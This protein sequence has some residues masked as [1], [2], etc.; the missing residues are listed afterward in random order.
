MKRTVFAAMV[1]ACCLL[2]IPKNVLADEAVQPVLEE[3]SDGAEP[4]EPIDSNPDEPLPVPGKVTDLAVG[5]HDDGASAKLIWAES[6]CASVYRIYR[7]SESE[8]LVELGFTE[9]TAYVDDEIM[10]DTIY[11]YYVIP[12]SDD[13]VQGEAANVKLVPAPHEVEGVEAE[14][15]SEK[16]VL[17][18]WNASKF[19]QKYFVYR[20]VKGGS[21]KKLEETEKTSFRDMGISGGKWYYYKIRAVNENGLKGKAK[22]VKVAPIPYVVK[23]IH[24]TG[25]S[26]K[27]V[28]LEWN[29]SK[30]AQKYLVYRKVGDGAYKKLTETK[31]TA[32]RDKGVARGKRYSYKIIAVN[33]NGGKGRKGTCVFHTVQA[34]NVAGQKYSYTQMEKD[35]KELT[36][37][38]SNY[39][40]MTSIGKSAQ[41]RALYD[42]AIG[43]PKAKK[44]LLVVCTLHARE[45]ICSVVAMQQ[46]EYYLR[47]YNKKIGGIKPKTSFSNMQIHYIVMANPDGTMI[48]QTRN[49]R[50]KS[51]VNGVDLNRNFP[52]KRFKV[53]GNKGQ[54]G[55]SGPY[56]LSEPESRA[57]ANFTKKLKRK[58]ALVGVVNY[59]AMGQIVFGSCKSK[60]V[61]K[62]TSRMYNIARSLTGYSSSA[63]YKAATPPSGG[64]YREYVMYYVKAPSITIEMGTT[65]APCSYWDYASAYR[66]NQY[67]VLKI[68]NALK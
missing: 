55:Y 32:F 53:G 1:C 11:V 28:L 66:K 42:F 35:M 43:N 7:E 36:A 57:I 20:K 23:G 48:S 14:R 63:G 38:Y 37:M 65:T 59:H 8:G 9:H 44:S 3:P 52:A 58:Q 67:V 27:K 19:A 56:A 22:S 31:R 46:I 47:N 41:G 30:F 6:E 68:A 40:R 54:E 17:L 49:S 4:S 18:K 25:E 34:V 61:S 5:Y 15:K 10:E 12:E 62:D 50:W 64:G 21:Y 13:G 39:C 60:A 2:G 51:N 29:P 26:E 33:E 24:T 16:Q 45:Y